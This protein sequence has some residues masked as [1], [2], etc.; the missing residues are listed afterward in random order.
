MAVWASTGQDGSGTGIFGQRYT[1]TPTAT[2]TLQAGC[3][4]APDITCHAAQKHFLPVKDKLDDNKDKGV[5]K[6]RKGFA[7]LTQ[8]SFGNPVSG[9][10]GYR[11]CVYDTNFGPPTFAIGALVAAGGSCGGNPCWKPLSDK[12]WKYVNSATNAHRSKKIVLKGGDP[13]TPKVILKGLGTNLAEL[14]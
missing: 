13:G 7:T 8:A 12:G 5:W 14:P 1:L 2:P 11:L 10:T 6:W 9:G 3:P 4:P